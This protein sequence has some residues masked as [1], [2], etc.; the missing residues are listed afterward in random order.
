MASTG[1]NSSVQDVDVAASRADIVVALTS[2]NDVRTIGAVAGALRD[3]LARYFGASAVR[4]VLADAGSTDGTRQAV[5]EVV[6]PAA[7]LE[8]EY[9]H[10]TELGDVPYHG[11]P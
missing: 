2:D 3:G 8:V 6:G 4:F 7:L 11:K 5:R 1:S 9:E 10:A